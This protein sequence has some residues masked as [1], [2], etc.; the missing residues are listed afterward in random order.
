M[1]S[2]TIGFG[3]ITPET[4]LDKMYTIAIIIVGT[5]MGAGTVANISSLVH[6]VAVN[7]DNFEH[8]QTCVVSFLSSRGLPNVLVQ[9]CE[10]YFKF[11]I[12]QNRGLS[13]CIILNEYLP[14]AIRNQVLLHSRLRVLYCSTIFDDYHSDLSLST[15]F[16]QDVALLLT[17]EVFT[18]G[19]II[20]QAKR[21]CPG[22]YF[23]KLGDIAATLN[24]KEKLLFGP[25]SCFGEVAL[26]DERFNNIHCTAGSIASLFL[27]DREQYSKLQLVYPKEFEY[28]REQSLCVHRKRW[29]GARLILRDKFRGAVRKIIIRN[30]QDAPFKL[31]RMASKKVMSRSSALLN[32]ATRGLRG[33]VTFGSGTIAKNSIV[34]THQ[35]DGMSM[36]FSSKGMDPIGKGQNIWR[37]VLLGV[38]LVN[39]FTIPLGSAFTLGIGNFKYLL[40]FGDCLL[41]MDITFQSRYFKFNAENKSNNTTRS[42]SS[43]RSVVDLKQ[44]I[45][46]YQKLSQI[47]RHGELLMDVLAVIPLEVIT[48]G[49]KI[50]FNQNKLRFMS[51]IL[52]LLHFRKI[53]LYIDGPEKLL[54]AMIYK[55]E[56]IYKVSKLLA[57]LLLTCHWFGCIWFF[58]AIEGTNPVNWAVRANVHD[59]S[60]ATQYIASLYWAAFTLTTVGYGDISPTNK[61]EQLFATF[62]LVC[63]TGMYT[64]VI[65]NLEEIVSQLDVTS[66]LY[67]EKREALNT[68]VQYRH[69][70]PACQEK[71]SLYLANI[72]KNNKGVSQNEILGM[73]PRRNRQQVLL[74]FCKSL[75]LSESLFKNCSSKFLTDVVLSMVPTEFCAGDML[76]E[77]HACSTNYIVLLD[78]SVDFLSEEFEILLTKSAPCILCEGDFLMKVQRV[79]HCRVRTYSNVLILY[80]EEY[81]KLLLKYPHDAEVLS[82]LIASSVNEI[83]TRHYLQSLDKNLKNSKMAQ[84]MAIDTSRAGLVSKLLLPDSYYCRLWTLILFYVSIYSFITVPY[85]LAFLYS[86]RTN[87]SNDRKY[88]WLMLDGPSDLINFATIWLRF[89]YFA[90]DAGGFITRNRKELRSA[91][92]SST[93]IWLDLIIAFPLQLLAYILGFTNAQSLVLCRLPQMLNAI[94]ISERVRRII[95]YIEEQYVHYSIGVWQAVKMFSL[96]ILL[97]H[98]LA[99]FYFI[100]ARIEGI[101]GTWVEYAGLADAVVFQ[102]YVV[103]LYWAVYTITT[104]GFGDVIPVTNVERCIAIVAMFIAAMLCDAGLTAILSSLI[105]THDAKS[106]ENV[107]RVNS[108]NK[109]LIYRKVPPLVRQKVQNYLLVSVVHTT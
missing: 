15:P 44:A 12:K 100:L 109:Y 32:A 69:L 40:Y 58:I 99:C 87:E 50:N 91:Y 43:K 23:I 19:E 108:I 68:Y 105:D 55:R 26:Y 104:V 66:T 41:L 82:K 62:V 45:P 94:Y 83:S 88:F 4:T 42:Y 77:K 13:E 106:G 46:W 54:R 70:S 102:Q 103:S 39:S 31:V 52:K 38:L 18:R 20:V 36:E 10:R 98:W 84:M 61:V 17:I 90:R 3:D 101:D 74:Q 9:H 14:D 81:D 60:Y 72:W 86:G 76:F 21:V 73:M 53:K 5:T 92:K 27:L 34:E 29:F 47:F 51:R 22:M 24:A 79:C 8:R 1:H 48:L 25:G 64:I 28:L 49:L 75:M 33:S 30:K 57:M 85:R 35:A 37:S 71:I 96:I 56:N 6:N 59:A 65:G 93:D 67:Q 95:D 78:G 97:S 89:N 63:G 11:E 16:L 7:D 80:S 2:T 107:R